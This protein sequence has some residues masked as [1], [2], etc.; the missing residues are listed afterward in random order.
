M[1][2]IRR[3]VTLWQGW[4]ARKRLS[5]IKGYAEAKNAVTQARKA[6]GRVNDPARTLRRIVTEQLA[7]E[8]E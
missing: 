5:A 7:R 6:H 2:R 4:K 3:I 1:I 8:C